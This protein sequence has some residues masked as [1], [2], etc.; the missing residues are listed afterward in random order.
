MPEMRNV[1]ER[2]F[3]IAGKPLKQGEVGQFAQSVIDRHLLMYPKELVQDGDKKE[4]KLTV[5]VKVDAE[6]VLEKVEILK[7]TPEL[8]EEKAQEFIDSVDV[9]VVEGKSKDEISLKVT[10]ENEDKAPVKYVSQMNKTELQDYLKG[11]E[12]EFPESA[13]KKELL[14]LA[15]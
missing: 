13:S 2:Q 1:S 3:I 15:K 14:E 11:K 6:E 8:T 5:A 10:A 12:I 7:N 4:D 9:V